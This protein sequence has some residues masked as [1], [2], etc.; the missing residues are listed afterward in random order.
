MKKTLLLVAAA[1]LIGAAQVNACG[2]KSKDDS[3]T[4]K[5]KTGSYSETLQR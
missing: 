4:D 3:K 1:L 5:G 2:D